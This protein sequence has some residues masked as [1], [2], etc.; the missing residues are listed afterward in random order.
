MKILYR[1]Q[2]KGGGNLLFKVIFIHL[3]GQIGYVRLIFNNFHNLAESCK[4]GCKN[5]YIVPKLF[6]TISNRLG[7]L[8][9][10]GNKKKIEKIGF[11]TTTLGK[12]V[13]TGHRAGNVDKSVSKKNCQKLSK[14]GKKLS[15]YILK[16]CYKHKNHTK[17]KIEKLPL[18]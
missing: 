18:Q 5:A 11:K 14:S 12:N 9:L 7:M 8:N 15:Q 3:R 10:V 6:L 16:P 17:I 4:N 2:C 1:F 13:K